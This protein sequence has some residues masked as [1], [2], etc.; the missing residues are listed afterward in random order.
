MSNKQRTLFLLA[1]L[2]IILMLAG[3]PPAPALAEQEPGGFRNVQLWVFPEYDDPRLLVMIQGEVEGAD[4]PATVRFLVPAAAEMYSAGSMDAQGSYSG[5]PPRREPSTLQG[6][7]EISYEV[8][9]SVFRVEYYDPLISG[10]PDK[11]VS[12]DFHPLYPISQLSVQVQEPRTSSNFS[13][14]PQADSTSSEES[15]RYHNY[16]YSG[17][18]KGQS[19]HF[20]ISY[21][22][23]DPNP[24]LMIE[25][26]A[27]T[28]APLIAGIAVGLAVLLGAGGLLVLRSRPK[29]RLAP[30]RSTRQTQTGGVGSEPRRNRF[31]S[32]CGQR[33]DGSPRFCPNCGHRIS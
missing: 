21:T 28:N 19:L 17:L 7:D 26:G 23:S 33:L 6:W 1:V 22:K 10:Q 15:F 29:R 11:A 25:A 9:T 32:Q 8:T 30:A 16:S 20:D 12:Y 24:S 3:T 5:G 13:V 2:G 31:C 4:I 27:S 18:D 14:A